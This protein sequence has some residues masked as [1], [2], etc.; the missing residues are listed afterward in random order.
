MSIPTTAPTLYHPIE[1]YIRTIQQEFHQ[2][3]K[4][5][6][7]LLS[8]LSGYIN[9]KTKANEPVRLTFICTHNSRR[10]HISQIWAQVAAYYYQIKGVETYSGGTEATAFNLRAVKAMAKVGFSI[11]KT[12][13]ENNPVY[14]VK[15]A[16]GATPIQAFSKVYDGEGNPTQDFAAILTC[17]QADKT[18]P[19]IPGA[20]MRIAI[21][22]D[23]PKEFDGTPQEETKYDERTQQIAREIFY[24][25]S[26]VKA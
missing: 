14:Q 15:F 25:V 21:P 6:K 8:E 2:I 4:R 23:D 12:G 16:D 24:A 11:E 7:E 18:C 19:F 9:S 26:L 22:Y 3:P 10:S 5:R 17:S 13:D 1:N 20:E